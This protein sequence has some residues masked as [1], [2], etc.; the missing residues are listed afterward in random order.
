M[1]PVPELVAAEAFAEVE[2]EAEEAAAL[3]LLEPGRETV[4]ASAASAFL[5]SALAAAIF[6]CLV[7]FII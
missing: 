4:A 2:V 5:A 6:S 1:A 7:L 3:L